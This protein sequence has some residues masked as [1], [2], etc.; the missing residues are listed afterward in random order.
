[1][2]VFG[3]KAY[4][5]KRHYGRGFSA[6]ALAAPRASHRSIIVSASTVRPLCDV[7]PEVSAHHVGYVGL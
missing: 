2:F 4:I 6:S 7:A 5:P 3:R 1:M